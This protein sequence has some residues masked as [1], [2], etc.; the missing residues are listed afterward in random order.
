MLIFECV[1]YLLIPVVVIIFNDCLLNE[2]I[3]LIYAI[4]SFYYR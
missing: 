1:N 4:T 3:E 2:M